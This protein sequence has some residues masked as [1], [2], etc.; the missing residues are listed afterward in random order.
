[1]SLHRRPVKRF[2]ASTEPCRRCGSVAREPCHVVR[3]GYRTPV[4]LP[5]VHKG[6]PGE[7]FII[8]ERQKV[9]KAQR[10]KWTRERQR[11]GGSGRA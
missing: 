4:I 7:R 1:M 9:P 6:R 8:G 2:Q 3:Q 11:E 10:R 5:E